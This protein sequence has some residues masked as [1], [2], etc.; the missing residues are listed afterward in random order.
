MTQSVKQVL[1]GQQREA[2]ADRKHEQ[3]EPADWELEGGPDLLTQEPEGP[4]EDPE[5]AFDL[6]RFASKGSALTPAAGTDWWTNEGTAGTRLIRG[7]LL[8]FADRQWTFGCD[9]RPMRA[10]TQLVALSGA[11]AW[12]RWEGKKPVEVRVR[13]PGQPFFTREELGHT[14]ETR[15]VRRPDG[16]AADPW[17]FTKVLYL[18]DTRSGEVFSFTTT[19]GGGLSA[20]A[21][22]VD[23]VAFMRGVRPG[24]FPVVELL[25]ADMET[26]YGRKSRP[27]FKI[28]GWC[29][30]EE[31]AKL[32][33]PL[34]SEALDDENPF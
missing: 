1:A 12:Q 10:G 6:Q 28:V 16:S 14:D 17:Q 11:T 2:Q 27:I 30:G 26:K 31:L 32:E 5:D 25:Y 22:L 18:A 33:P 15:W 8:K 7:N 3:H 29:G 20:I 23:Q 13:V 9:A 19:S 4:P 21:D 34:A 24:A